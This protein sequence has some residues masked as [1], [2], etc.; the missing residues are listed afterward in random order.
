MKE[1]LPQQQNISSSTQAKHSHADILESIAQ[2]VYVMDEAGRFIY[3]NN[4]ASERYG[5]DKS[6]FIG[7]SPQVLAAPGK[8]NMA[9][10]TQNIS[11][12]FNGE[13]VKFEFCGIS[14]DKREFISEVSLTKGRYQNKDVVVAVGHNISEKKALELE[15]EA[16]I[17]NLKTSRENY[18]RLSQMLRLMCDNV[19]DMIWAKDI[20][21][22]YLFANEAICDILLNA[23]DTD[24]PLGKNDLFFA[25]RE[26]NSKP[27]DPAWHTFGEICRDSDQTVMEGKKAQR[28]DEYGNVKGKYLFL[29]VF[30]APFVDEQGNMIG[31]V[32]CGRDVT[33]ERNLQEMH[34]KIEQELQAK[35]ARMDA[36]VSALPD[37]IFVVHKNGVIADYHPPAGAKLLLPEQQVIGTSISDLFDE[38]EAQRQL[39]FYER[40]IETGEPRVFR[41]QLELDENIVHYEARISRMDND[42]LLAVVRDVTTSL[43]MEAEITWQ[44]SLLRT[45]MDLATRFINLPYAA[46][47]DEVNKALARMGEFTQSDRVYIFDYDFGR[48]IQINRFEWCAQGV[49]P[50]IENLQEVPNSLF[51]DW[52]NAHKNGRVKSVSSVKNLPQGSNLRNI[53]EPQ[54]IK[55]LITIPLMHGHECLGYIGFDAVKTEKIWSDD[56]LHLLRLFAQLLTN[57]KIKA[58]YESEL[59]R[60]EEQFRQL[61]D[62]LP[63]IVLIHHERQIVYANRAAIQAVG[64]QMDEL[65]GTSVMDYIVD[66][67]QPQVIDIMQRR[68][69]GEIVGDYELH[70]K[71]KNG[72]KRDVIVRTSDIIF[73]G[74]KSVIIILIDIT[75]RKRSEILLR[76]S[77]EKFRNLAQLAPFAIMIYQ[78]ENWVYTNN[79]GEKMSGYS[80]GELYRMKYWEIVA[81]E[82][83][84]MI[85][86]RGRQRQYGQSVPSGYEFKIITK[87]G[88]EKWVILNGALI[89]FKGKPAGLVS[90]ADITELKAIENE[91]K[92]AKERAEKSDSLKTAFMNNISH[93]V[94][95][96]LN[97]IIGFTDLV[98][99]QDITPDEKQTYAIFLKQSTNRLIQTITDY[100][101]SS[102]IVSGNQEV[103][104]TIITP[105][106]LLKDLYDQ[107]QSQARDKNLSL[108]LSVDEKNLNTVVDSDPELLKKVFNHLLSNA[109]KF[110]LEG[111]ISMGLY[112]DN[113]QLVFFIK[114]T[115]VGVKDEAIPFIF[116]FFRQEDQSSVRLFEGSGL[117]LSIAKGLIKLLGGKIWLDTK[118]GEGSTFY[119]SIPMEEKKQEASTAKPRPSA[120]KDHP[121]RCILLVEDEMYNYRF[122]TALLK[123]N[124]YAEVILATTGAEA[125][126]KCKQHPEINMV[127]MDL[128][129]PEMSG[130][131][132]TRHIKAMRSDLPII[133]ITAFAMSG[134]ERKARDVGCDDYIPKPV[135]KE[136]LFSKMEKLGL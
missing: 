116:D 6:F 111:G 115:G 78:N 29:D 22:R 133:A 101:D 75:E 30:K 112:P 125:I 121:R 44:Q 67:D 8:N 53:L 41:Y 97:S 23:S 34:K 1:P 68:M 38:K 98:L 63:D 135:S 65:T 17:E 27:E 110:T 12:A 120:E 57:L 25:Q 80:A 96:P 118:K 113:G 122:M 33:A 40:C 102:I 105:S 114:D 119:F 127:L 24:E 62:D 126:E 107:Y 88:A 90:I 131:E 60:S 47:G 39:A 92:I 20:N 4:S 100:M 35:T 43:Q 42:H 56:E 103:R 106:Y 132:A 123:I 45:L 99:S 89:E 28:F 74:K 16:V 136:V 82:F 11:R 14:K 21:K 72:E 52:V 51:P 124:N 94:R 73:F 18:R 15:K 32:G 59:V 109:L 5:Y 129:L 128:K 31:T 55:S 84:Q 2:S 117:G 79:A 50:E 93:E 13:P 64:Y 48:D 9:V 46:F 130:F 19:P 77:E 83:Q 66:E 26:R 81:P 76:E 37:L 61:L 49:T 54:D 87:E 85:K 7:K 58:G 3:V 10:L 71:R 104:T 108:H 86:D 36:L 70:V 69:A 91:L 95:T 134:D